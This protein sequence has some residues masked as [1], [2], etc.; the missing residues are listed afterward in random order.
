MKAK[1]L[2]PKLFDEAFLK[3]TIPMKAL[4]TV[5]YCPVGGV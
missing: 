2:K 3:N 4:F 5:V 1:S